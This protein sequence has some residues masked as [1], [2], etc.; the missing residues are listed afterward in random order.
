MP[1]TIADRI[2]ASILDESWE[3]AEAD[4]QTLTH[5]LHRYSGKFIPQIAERAITTLSKPGELILDPYC[6]SG[7]TPLECALT[8]RRCIGVDLSPLAV[9]I[10]RT[11]IT[12]V[13]PGALTSL[14]Q[15]MRNEIEQR[16]VSDQPGLFES[17]SAELIKH[18][19]ADPR[20]T[21]AWYTKWFQPKILKELVVIYQSIETLSNPSL[22]NL[23]F[24]AFSDILRR[25]SNA[26]SGYPNVM[27][28]KNAPEKGSA[29]APYLRSLDKICTMAAT[30]N[31]VE[32]AWSDVE[33][34]HGNACQLNIEDESIDA[35]ISHPP[36]IGSIP[37]AE[38]GSLSLKWLGHDPKKLDSELTGGRRQSTSVVSRFKDGYAGMIAEAARVLKAG[39]NM[40]LMVGNPVVRGELVDLADMTIELAEQSGFEL[41]TRTTRSG[42]N[43]RANKM[44]A[45]HLLFFAKKSSNNQPSKKQKKTRKC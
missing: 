21:D 1:K 9:L 19:E 20:L 45:E 32:G 8:G 5:N 28:D 25:S 17:S 4:T 27:Y 16:T 22:Q 29:L 2:T 10:A 38:Y 40:F 42:V 24:V 39:R 6:G 36:Y 44:G 18:I 7:T 31:D 23:A 26:H 30:L 34:R 12:P 14:R 35:V 3:Y 15:K 13:S 41:V 11:K 37:Y 43:R 33:V